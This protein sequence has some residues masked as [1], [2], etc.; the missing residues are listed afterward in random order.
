MGIHPF[1]NMLLGGPWIYVARVVASSLHQYLKYIMN[2]MM[3]TVKNDETISMIINVTIRFIKIEDGKDRNIH[4]S[5]LWTQS[6]FLRILCWESQKYQKQAANCFL[7]QGIPF[8]FGLDTRMPKWVNMI[9][10]KCVDERFKLRYKFKND[11]YRRITRI[12]KEARIEGRELKEEELTIPPLRTTFPR[13]SQVIRSN[14]EVLKITNLCINT[15]N[16]E[17]RSGGRDAASFVCSRH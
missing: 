5:G 16:D 15:L 12:K 3:V 17:G 14:G 1:Y 2:G 11:D 13:P 10:A 7:K 4:L 9:K 6:G 8:Q